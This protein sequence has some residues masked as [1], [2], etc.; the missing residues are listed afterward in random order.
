[1]NI[2]E[3]QAKEILK[4]YGLPV[5]KG[6]SYNKNL[7]TL[8]SDIKGGLIEKVSY[9]LVRKIGEYE[10]SKIVDM[11]KKRDSAPLFKDTLRAE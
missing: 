5:L 7:E 1:M 8:D 6:K 10:S 11:Q 3:Y 9:A 2:H 4:N